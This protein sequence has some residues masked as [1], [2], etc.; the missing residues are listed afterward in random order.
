MA[1]PERRVAVILDLVRSRQASDRKDLHDRFAAAL[2]QVN[3]EVGAIQ[4]LAVVVG[5]EAVVA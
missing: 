1:T 4:P 5:D 2:S 3:E